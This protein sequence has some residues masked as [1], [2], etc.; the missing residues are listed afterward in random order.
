MEEIAAEEVK[1]LSVISLYPKK[2]GL[3]LYGESGRKSSPI[4]SY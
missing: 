4:S 3:F 1:S 2:M